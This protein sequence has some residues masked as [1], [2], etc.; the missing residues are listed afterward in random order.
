METQPADGASQ[1]APL[2]CFQGVAYA[3]DDGQ[4]PALHGLS[5]EVQPGETVALVGPS[6]AGK[7]TVAH[8]LLRF[9]EPQAGRITVDGQPLAALPP[10]AWRAR[11]AWVPQHPYLFHGTVA[12]NIR[13]ACPTATTEAV[14][15][16]ARQAQAHDFVAALPQGYETPVGEGG[17]R[18]SGGQ[19][20]RIALARAFLKDAPLLIF[21]EATANLDPEIEGLV[22]AALARL[23]AGRTA[24]LIAHRLHTVRRA[25]RIV[26]MAGGRVVEEG[27][28]RS[29]VEQAGLYRRL[30][31]AYGGAP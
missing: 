16:A 25:D 2:L 1:A 8:L 19:A 3:Y 13:L 28:H 5:F 31:R 9:L 30:L 7:S 11:V 23:L 14:I 21:D 15:G 22:Q 4:R 17:S 6:G 18:L 10:A 20:Q 27:D 12:D 26:V 29:L 24:L